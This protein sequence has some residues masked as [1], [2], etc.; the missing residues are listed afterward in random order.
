MLASPF[1]VLRFI[2]RNFS[3][4]CIF[5][6]FGMHG[7]F[8][9]ISYK[10]P[11]SGRRFFDFGVLWDWFQ[12]WKIRGLL[13][14]RYLC[15]QNCVWGKRIF[16]AVRRK[17]FWFFAFFQMG[18]FERSEIWFRKGEIFHWRLRRLLPEMFISGRDFWGWFRI[19]FYFLCILSFVFYLYS[20]LRWTGNGHTIWCTLFPMAFLRGIFFLSTERKKQRNETGCWKTGTDRGETAGKAVD[21]PMF[22]KIFF[23]VKKSARL[24]VFVQPVAFLQ[25]W[26]ERIL[27]P[28]TAAADFSPASVEI[29]PQRPFYPQICLVFSTG[30]C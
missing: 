21:G 30:I 6:S 28:G 5:I 27:Q 19:W 20:F 8:P 10:R 29:P 11:R 15:W 13:W 16:F 25:V 22:F 17:F 12:G 23:H 7:K 24:Y 2:G 3:D 14:D 4:S 18:S 26:S 9:L 1:W